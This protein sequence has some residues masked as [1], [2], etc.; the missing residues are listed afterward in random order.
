M[1]KKI[2]ET[3]KFFEPFAWASKRGECRRHLP[4]VVVRANE[5]LYEFPEVGVECW[6]GDFR[7]ERRN[8]RD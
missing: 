6:C 8:A 5:K 4:Q 1:N 3:C 7:N 2:C